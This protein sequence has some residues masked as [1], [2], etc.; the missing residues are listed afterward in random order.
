MLT[1]LANSQ[2]FLPE[3][4]AQL[5][6]RSGVKLN[7]RP[8]SADDEERLLGFFDGVTPDDLRFRFLSALKHVGRPFVHQLAEIDHTRTEHL[9]AFDARDGALVGSAMI[10]A[11]EPMQKA[12]VAVL[13]RSD[14]KGHGIGWAM[15]KHACDYA[16]ARG[17][18]RVECIE[19]ADN[20]VAMSLEEEMGFETREYPGDSTLRLV[21]KDLEDAV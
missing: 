12:E 6:T 5:T 13:V 17:I 1:S 10:A 21:S 2:W 19:S 4:S 7:V 14:L 8:A 3:W 16:A 18:R 11:D 15:L 9:L 20:R